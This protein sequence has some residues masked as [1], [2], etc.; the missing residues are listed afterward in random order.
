MLQGMG[1]GAVLVKLGAD[2]SLLL[3]GACLG[4]GCSFGQPLEPRARLLCRRCCAWVHRRARPGPHPAASL[5]SQQG[6]RHDG[7]VHAVPAPCCLHRA[8]PRTQH[9]QPLGPDAAAGAGRRCTHAGRCCAGRRRGRLLH[10]CV[11]C[12]HAGGPGRTRRAAL[13]QRRGLHLRAAAGRHAQHA[14]QAGGG[15]AAG[16]C[17]A[18]TGGRV[19]GRCARV[20]ARCCSSRA[21]PWQWRRRALRGAAASRSTAGSRTA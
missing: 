14:Q 12:G 15:R 6:G 21:R 5:Q 17:G 7:C 4:R 20:K 8:T 1:V 9:V 2:G 13:C 11:H 18:V 19:G 3:P 10:R 16:Q